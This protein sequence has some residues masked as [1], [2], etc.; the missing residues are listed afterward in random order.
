L[1]VNG[2]TT[3][4]F[5]VKLVGKWMLIKHT[6]PDKGGKS[7]NRL[8]PD[9]TTTYEFSKDGTYKVTYKDKTGMAVN[10]GKWKVTDKGKKIHLYNNKAVSPD[11]KVIIPESD[12]K[13]IIKLTAMELVL[14]E[15]RFDEQP[16]GTSY[17]TKQK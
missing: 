9:E 14:Q 10:K 1:R 6:I 7:I 12:D 13:T 15:Y 8:A 17:Y 3:D 5:S 4:T 2:Q 11:S 16:I